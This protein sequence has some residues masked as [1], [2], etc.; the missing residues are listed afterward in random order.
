MSK[1]SISGLPGVSSPSP[2]GGMPRAPSS[3]LSSSASPPRNTVSN[4]CILNKKVFFLQC[5][6]SSEHCI[7]SM[8]PEQTK[9]LLTMFRLF[10]ILRPLNVPWTKMIFCCQYFASSEQFVHLMYP[11]TRKFF[12]DNHN[13][14]REMRYGFVRQLSGFESK[15]LSK[16]QNGLHR[17]PSKGV[18]NTL[19]KQ[20]KTLIFHQF[21]VFVFEDIWLPKGGR[22]YFNQIKIQFIR[23]LRSTLWKSEMKDRWNRR[24]R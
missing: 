20:Q 21:F 23:N 15:D 5:F 17:V 3:R 7:Q 2:W 19:A 18:D 8:Y 6:A 11:E 12:V 13:F 9:I 24:F 4:Q 16:I 10:G 22:T 1:N 14:L